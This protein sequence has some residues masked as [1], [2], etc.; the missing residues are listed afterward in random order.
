MKT[1]QRKISILLQK[2]ILLQKFYF[3]TKNNTSLL[4]YAAMQGRD[5]ILEL[6]LSRGA[7]PNIGNNRM[8]T[9]I[10]KAVQRG[11]FKCLQ[12]LLKGGA[13]LNVQDEDRITPLHRGLNEL[14]SGRYLFV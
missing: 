13:K 4:H 1:E 7:N 14:V 11:E 8:T 12:V 9:P 5:D 10:H 6:L 3:A 2:L